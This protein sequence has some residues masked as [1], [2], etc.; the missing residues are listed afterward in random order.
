MAKQ[1]LKRKPKPPEFRP[2]S[3]TRAQREVIAATIA[4]GTIETDAEAALLGQAANTDPEAAR[5]FGR[6]LRR[7]ARRI[8]QAGLDATLDSAPGP[9]KKIRRE[10]SRNVGKGSTLVQV[11]PLPSE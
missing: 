8:R 7:E 3:F 4:R 9:R 5:V 2:T 1:T 6:H 11:A 10:L